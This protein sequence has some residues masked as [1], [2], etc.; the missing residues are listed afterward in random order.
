MRR[1]QR[2]GIQVKLPVLTVL[3]VLACVVITDAVA[4]RHAR[5]A[6]M[7]SE[8]TRLQQ[9][10]GGHLRLVEQWSET[11]SEVT[12]VHS[13][14]PFTVTA[15][16]GFRKGISKAIGDGIEPFDVLPAALQSER[17]NEAVSAA[18]P[19]YAIMLRRYDPFFRDVVARTDIDAVYLLNL[20]GRVIYASHSPGLV[21]AELE[22]LSVA[23]PT[24]AKLVDDLANSDSGVSYSDLRP[25]R[26]G[27][28]GAVSVARP[29]LAEDGVQIA[30]AIY[31]VGLSGLHTS[32]T[33]AWLLGQTGV[34]QFA[35]VIDAEAGAT[36]SPLI[37]IRADAAEVDGT[38]YLL[39]SSLVMALNRTFQLTIGQSEAELTAPIRVMRQT[40]VR[41]GLIEVVLAA[42]VALIFAI[43]LTRPLG[44]ILNALTQVRLGNAE[45]AIPDTRRHDEIGKIARAVKSFAKTLQENRRLAEESAFKN[46]AFEGSSAPLVLVDRDMRIAYA[47]PAFQTLVSDNIEALRAMSINVQP[48][49]LVGRSMDLFQSDPEQ[50]RGILSVPD[51]MPYKTEVEF[52]D[53]TI[54]MMFNQVRDQEGTLLGFV[55]EWE[56]ATET[57]KQDALIEAI[58]TRHI[59]AEFDMQGNLVF[60]ND[61]FCSFA[62]QARDDVLGQSLDTLLAPDDSQPMDG[63]DMD[64][65]GDIPEHSRFLSPVTDHL[66]EGGM[67]TILSRSGMPSRLL[68]IG[69]DITRDHKRLTRAEGEKEILINS[70]TAVVEALRD[71]LAR[72]SQGNLAE[73]ISADF[74]QDY[75]VLKSDFNTALDRLSAALARVVDNANAIRGEASDITSAADDLSRRTERQAATLE[76]TAAALDQLTQNLK[77]A[78]GEAQ[79]AHDVV[80]TAREDA[81]ESG[82]VVDQAV[83][84][85]GEIEKSSNRISRIIEVIDDIAFQT[86]LLALNAGVEAARAGDAGR[87]F[88]VVASEVR[89]LAQRSAGAAREITELI[90]LSRDH[91]G[92]G[93]ELVGKAGGALSG[94]VTS[95]TDIAQHVS[96][97]ATSAAEQ[98]RSIDE[99]NAAVTNLDQV[100]QQNAAMFQET[101][102]ASHALT[103]EA[104]Q[105]SD[106]V[107][108]FVLADSEVAAEEGARGELKPVNAPIAV[109]MGQD[110]D[111]E[112]DHDGWEEF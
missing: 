24:F 98:S 20:D 28:A 12:E 6:L 92:Q 55:V 22:K 87:G 30:T 29:I 58:N 108:Q 62:G 91:V 31:D 96:E 88:A 74:P 89:A 86:N 101:T 109:A 68:L 57:R 10:L 66:M 106:T 21:G 34:L 82:K 38:D 11:V 75:D 43:S 61:A 67:T 2:L 71:A 37:D 79:L 70:Q 18:A 78:A 54:A 103:Q 81:L 3:L 7:Q 110:F 49:G 15:A 19:T 84:A 39:Q 33:D 105:L 5:D 25:G 65:L 48:D 107:G 13:R 85:M 8:T 23:G 1:L 35:E 42:I 40:L 44:R 102:A 95:V 80:T 51:R 47:N 4:Y 41:D 14:N 100:T 45:I 104:Q 112:P 76:E 52:G 26:N 9:T 93:V 97:I 94:I 77:V 32:I 46:A 53:R 99:I 17:P 56:D 27:R 63:G 83:T 111:A 36:A 90:S 72:L 64:E 73:A 16:R 69:Q 60:A 59:M 50:V